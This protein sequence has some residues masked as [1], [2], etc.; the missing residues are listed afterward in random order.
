MCIAHNQ[1]R[2]FYL[3]GQR[4]NPQLPLLIS[5]FKCGNFEIERRFYRRDSTFI[6]YSTLH[7]GAFHLIYI[8]CNFTVFFHH[9]WHLRYEMKAA[10]QSPIHH[11]HM[12]TYDIQKYVEA[13]SATALA[14]RYS[15]TSMKTPRSAKQFCLGKNLLP[16][17]H[18]FDA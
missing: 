9:E 10:N 17:G 14:A 12:T 18:T 13:K 4:K 15:Q 16:H 2:H 7:N 3:Y 11:I 5:R 6:K 8:L 1:N